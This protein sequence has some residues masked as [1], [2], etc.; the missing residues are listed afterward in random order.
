MS[1]GKQGQPDRVRVLLVGPSLRYFGGQP[2]Q[3]DNLLERLRADGR[4]DAKAAEPLAA[5][6]DATVLGTTLTLE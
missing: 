4:V 6:P 5:H 2:V 1:T 3:A